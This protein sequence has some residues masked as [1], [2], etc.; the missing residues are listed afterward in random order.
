[1]TCEAHGHEYMPRNNNIVDGYWDAN[2]ALS[3]C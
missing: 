3:F 2:P 1:M